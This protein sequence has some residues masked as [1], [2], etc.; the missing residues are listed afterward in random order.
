MMD[1]TNLD[2]LLKRLTAQRLPGIACVMTQGQEIIYE[3]YEGY[4]DL[5]SGRP[6][7]ED[8]VFRIYSMTKLP[9]YTLCM[10]LYERGL[11][12]PDD[13]LSDYFP[14]Y[15][16]LKR[17]VQQD[18]GG[19]HVAPLQRTTQ[20]RHVLTMGVGLRYGHRGGSQLPTEAAM[21]RMRQALL[22]KGAYSLREEIRAAAEVPM[23]F[24]PGTHWMYGFSS[25][26]AAGLCEVLTGKEI[27]QALKDDLLTPLEMDSTGMRFFGDIPQRLSAYYEADEQLRP[28][29]GVPRMDEKHLPGQENLRGCPRMFAT[30]RDFAH[31]GIMLANGGEYHGQR[32]MGRQTI[33][34]MRTNQLSPAQLRDF[35]GR[36]TRG[37]SY[38][39]GV[40]T[41][42][43]RAEAGSNG[44]LGEFG[45]EGGSGP[46]FLVDPEKCMSLTVM[47][48]RSGPD[49]AEIHLKIRNTAYGCL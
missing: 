40:R 11:F 47:Y 21:D 2:A 49:L 25:E 6:L 44:S 12:L 36:V 26:L 42:M 5:E 29:R 34:L 18:N 19:Y 28:V 13:P 24:E 8:T 17:F 1:F 38:G 7:R 41:L 16:Q 39:Y 23:A 22:A 10:L 31:L 45:W 46:Y 3:R 35:D 37:Y 33:D 15:G 43:D 48:Q 4:A 20:V 9:V 27:E 32:V 14:E 30:A